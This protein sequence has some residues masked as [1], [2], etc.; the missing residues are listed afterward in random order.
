M[1]R[2]GLPLVTAQLLI[3]RGGEMD[4]PGKAGLASLTANLLTKGAA[5]KTAPQI[6]AADGTLCCAKQRTNIH[7]GCTDL[8]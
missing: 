8:Y 6:A 2:A 4:P 1:R 7:C 5:G 3:R